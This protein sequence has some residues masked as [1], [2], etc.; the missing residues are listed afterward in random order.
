MPLRPECKY[1]AVILMY[2]LDSGFER[3]PLATSQCPI[4]GTKMLFLCPYLQFVVV[5]WCEFAI[6]VARHI[7]GSH[8]LLVGYLCCPVEHHG[9]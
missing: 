3:K 7:H 1:N 4:E 8:P 2:L 5:Y 6:T 9:E